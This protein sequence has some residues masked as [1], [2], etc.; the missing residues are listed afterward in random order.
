[1]LPSTGFSFYY[2][3]SNDQLRLQRRKR[4]DCAS[5]SMTHESNGLLHFV[6]KTTF[7]SLGMQSDRYFSLRFQQNW[8]KTALFL[9]G[10]ERPCEKLAFMPTAITALRSVI[11]PSASRTSKLTCAK[12]RLAILKAFF[13]VPFTYGIL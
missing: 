11:L 4:P 8:P 5:G 2:R 6:Y 7:F 9:S 10:A 13:F 3:A 12:C 1:M